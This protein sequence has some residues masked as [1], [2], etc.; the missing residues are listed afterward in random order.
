VRRLV[1]GLFE[2]Q[3]RF[4]Q[5]P[6]N[7]LIAWLGLLIKEACELILKLLQQ[8]PFKSLDLEHCHNLIVLKIVTISLNHIED[9]SFLLLL[10]APLLYLLNILVQ[11]ITYFIKLRECPYWMSRCEVE[12]WLVIFWNT[13]VDVQYF[14]DLFRHLANA[15]TCV[16]H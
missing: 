3:L 1:L 13:L 10:D 6:L 9:C 4:F 14:V 5:E 7:E 15:L 2:Q 11:F 16:L 8:F 12:L